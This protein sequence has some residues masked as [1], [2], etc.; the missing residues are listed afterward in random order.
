[1]TREYIDFP[2]LLLFWDGR[3]YAMGIMEGCHGYQV[4]TSKVNDFIA[5]QF[6]R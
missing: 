1:M 3:M 6:I 2:L 5:L 4:Q